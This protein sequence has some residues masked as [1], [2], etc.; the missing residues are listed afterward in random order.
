MKFTQGAIAGLWIVEIEP[1][2][3]HRG[4]FARSWCQDEFEELGLVA[5]WKQSN[6][7][8]SPNPGTMRGL[9]YQLPPHSETKLVRCTQGAVFDVVV[10]LRPNSPTYLEWSGVK[11]SADNHK[12]IWAPEGCAHG[13]LTLQPN[14]EAFYLT[15]NEYWPRAVRGIRYDDPTF[16]IRWPTAI[17][18]VPT[19]YEAWPDFEKD[20]PH[21]WPQEDGE[22]I[23][24]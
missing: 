8:F 15:S 12:S 16:S 19:G 18:V 22:D 1:I 2:G 6:I 7:Q 10:D 24:T 5:E 13:Y 4:F 17:E 9:H 3:D 14:S 20:D 23:T 21:F 11:L